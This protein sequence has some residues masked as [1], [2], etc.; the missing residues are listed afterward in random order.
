MSEVIL[1]LGCKCSKQQDQVQ[2]FPFTLWG[3]LG[4]SDLQ[5]GGL[6]TKKTNGNCP[7]LC[8]NLST[9][10]RSFSVPRVSAWH[11]NHYGAMKQLKKFG[12]VMLS[13]LTWYPIWWGEYP[14]L[15]CRQR[16]TVQTQPDQS[17]QFSCNTAGN[18][19]TEERLENPHWGRLFESWPRH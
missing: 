4:V 13:Q 19:G 12:A 1:L 10:P 8:F 2:T 7:K 6:S 11:S 5:T 9:I 14:W 3:K 15:L 16:T 18:S 17:W